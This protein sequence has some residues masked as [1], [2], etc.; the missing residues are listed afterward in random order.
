[1]EPDPFERISP[2]DEAEI[3]HTITAAD[4]A[5]FSALTGDDNPL[6]MDD[7]FAASTNFQERVVHGMLTASFISTIIGTKLPGRGAMWFEQRTQFLS[8]VRIGERIRVLARVLHKSAAQRVVVLQTEVYG[9][10]GRKVIDGEAKVKI[11]EQERTMPQS[12]GERKAVIISGSGRGIGAAIARELAA[13]GY[14]VIVNYLHSEDRA[15]RV[16]EEIA[17]NG[18]RATL[19]R[20]DV[21]DEAQV[22]A[23]VDLALRTYGGLSGLVNNACGPTTPGGFLDLSWKDVQDQLDVQLRGAFN[24]TRAVLPHLVAQKSGVVVNIASVYADSVPPVKM[25][26]YAAAKSALVSFTRSLAVEFGPLG[27]R[28]NTVSPGMTRSEFIGNVPEKT[29]LTTK[30]QTPLRRLGE[31]ED[32]AGTVAFLF[33]DKARF[34]SGEN[35]RVCGG[36]VMQ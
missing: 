5:A 31:V 22:R 6:H 30:M 16:K 17:G 23:M 27:I 36:I 12:S 33:S 32:I 4:V 1:M 15:A 19:C 14:P 8:P 28:V 11:I 26:P 3:F 7:A 21:T 25:L 18:G 24:L 10:D 35:I 9:N 34:I 20:A 29:K 13:S 2:G